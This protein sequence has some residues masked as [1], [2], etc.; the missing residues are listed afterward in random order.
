MNRTLRFFRWKEAKWKKLATARAMA[1]EMLSPEHDEGLK[2][3]SERQAKLCRD[4]HNAC[5]SKWRTVPNMMKSAKMEVADPKLLFA[6]KEKERAKI[7]SRQST[8]KSVSK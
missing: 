2:A 5:E 8:A 7:F 4:F 3:Y 1:C 6:R